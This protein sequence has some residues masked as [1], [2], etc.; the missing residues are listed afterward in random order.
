METVPQSAHQLP[1]TFNDCGKVLLQGF[2]PAY[3]REPEFLL[4]PPG[5]RD[6]PP[7]IPEMTRILVL[8]WIS[9]G[10]PGLSGLQIAWSAAI[11]TAS[12]AQKACRLICHCS[13]NASNMAALAD[14]RIYLGA[15]LLGGKKNGRP[16][17]GGGG[18]AGGRVYEFGNKTACYSC[19][20]FIYV[21]IASKCMN[22]PC[23]QASHTA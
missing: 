8:I 3:D 4:N 13:I 9:R 17:T 21:Y 10:S 19:W 23:F 22:C 7:R 20:R 16:Q 6:T 1:P 2:R 15:Q 11:A 14:Q 5:S 18:R 12:V